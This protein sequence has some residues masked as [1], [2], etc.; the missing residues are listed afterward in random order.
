MNNNLGLL[1]Y[2]FLIIGIILEIP[3]NIKDNNIKNLCYDIIQFIGYILI[4]HDLFL[5]KKHNKK[6]NKKQEEHNKK[7]KE[8]EFG[9]IVLFLFYFY[10]LF[11]SGEKMYFVTFVTLLAHLILIKED[12]EI[13]NVGYILSII[14]YLMK[15][16]YYIND[17]HH[18]NKVKISAYGLLILFYI[19]KYFN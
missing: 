12:N 9:H 11:L 3:N 14:Y 18:I 7:H 5:K 19:S 16:Q 4:M 6:Y 10:S 13:I 1:G 8:Y 15:L 2:L 17:I